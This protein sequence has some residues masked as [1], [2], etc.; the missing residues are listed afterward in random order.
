MCGIT[1]IVDYAGK[2]SVNKAILSKMVSALS[3]R[4]PDDAGCWLSTNGMV[5]LGHTRLSIVDLSHHGHQPMLCPSGRY[6][7]T[8]NGEIYNASELRTQLCAKGYRFRGHSDTEVVLFSIIEWGVVDAV[9]KF[10]GMFAFGLWDNEQEMFFLCRDRFGI[11][12]L[13]YTVSKGVFLFASELKPL[14]TSSVFDKSVSE[15]ALASYL[16]LGYVNG[17]QSIF[18]KT[19]RLLPGQI[20]TYKKDGNIT[21][22]PYWS[23]QSAV[24][25][26]ISDPFSGSFSEA[27]DKLHDLLEASVS[28][29]LAAD[30]PVGVFLSGGIDSSMLSAIAANVSCKPIKTFSIGFS[31]SEFNEAHDAK[32]IANFLGTDHIEYYFQ[33]SELCDLLT[34]MPFVYDEPFSDVSQLPT[35]LVSQIASKDVKVVLSGDG[36]DELFAGYRRYLFT[37]KM[38]NQSQIKKYLL[39]HA[40]RLLSQKQLRPLYKLMEK[41]F[42]SFIPHSLVEK[43][44]KGSRFLRASTLWDAY[45]QLLS[46][47]NLSADYLNMDEKK[48]EQD[49]LLKKY[50]ENLNHLSG[51]EQQM[52]WDTQI[53][54]PDDLLTKVDRATMATGLEARVPFLDH[55]IFEFAWSLPIN[56]KCNRQSSKIIL[57][58]VLEKYIPRDLF[59]RPKKG[60]SVP[61]DIWLKK[62][63]LRDM[64]DHY[65]SKTVLDKF[66]VLNSQK[67][68]QLW[69]EYR[70]GQGHRGRQVWTM[71]MLVLWLEKN[72][73]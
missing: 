54:L 53:Y 25:Q 49:D 24:A 7:L 15:E 41:A 22:T 31:E 44:D 63:R 45:V 64:V 62:G 29:R 5:G 34:Q 18:E 26:S 16:S 58:S 51:V 56:W 10:N 2:G 37:E 40:C 28:R 1:G 70:N 52:Y 13:Y 59:E 30:V 32:N 72:G 35:F 69:H 47:I 48:I 38:F 61:I 57:K 4:G 9:C 27:S 8:Y 65:L 17:E 55:N 43:F 50:K 3:H 67:I 33:E 6:V 39:S 68:E 20:L 73:L 11:K 21:T 14:M 12:P 46:S 71:L 36:G 60:F 42:P 66:S 23:M 19:K